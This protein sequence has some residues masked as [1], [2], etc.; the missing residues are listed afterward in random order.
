MRLAGSAF[1]SPDDS[2]I[3]HPEPPVSLVWTSVGGGDCV[4]TELGDLYLTL[5]H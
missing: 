4:R 3:P 5:P 2:A 1:L